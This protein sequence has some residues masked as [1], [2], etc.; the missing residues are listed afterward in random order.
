[1]YYIYFNL[2][3]ALKALLANQVTAAQGA[4][5]KINNLSTRAGIEALAAPN[6]HLIHD[7]GKGPA[8]TPFPSKIKCISTF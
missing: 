6:C 4:A 8:S 1:L 3:F 5:H 7:P 2:V